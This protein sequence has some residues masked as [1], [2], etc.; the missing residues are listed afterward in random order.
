MRFGGKAIGLLRE[1]EPAVNGTRVDTDDASDV[2]YMVAL[3]NG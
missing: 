1:I 2:L 3:L